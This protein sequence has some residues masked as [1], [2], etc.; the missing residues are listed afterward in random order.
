[1]KCAL[2]GFEPEHDFAVCSGCSVNKS[3]SVSKCPHCGYRFVQDSAIVSLLRRV[4]RR[5]QNK[6]ASLPRTDSKP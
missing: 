2:C 6:P 1:M 3:C 5:L 4:L